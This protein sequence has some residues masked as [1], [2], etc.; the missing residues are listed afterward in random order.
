MEKIISILILFEVS[1]YK[2]MFTVLDIFDLL[3][4]T[5]CVKPL[6]TDKK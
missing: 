6:F 3:Y 1:M 2:D 4:V 5:F